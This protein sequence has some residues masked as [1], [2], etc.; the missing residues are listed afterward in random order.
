[1]IGKHQAIYCAW[2]ASK[3]PDSSSL[4]QPIYSHCWISRP[5]L[6]TYL[7]I[8]VA[9]KRDEITLNVLDSLRNTPYSVSELE[10]LSGGTA[11]FIYLAELQKP[12]EDG[13]KEVIVKHSEDFIANHPSFKL[14]QDRSRIEVECLKALSQLSAEDKAES[15]DFN[16]HVRTPKV[17]HFDGTDHT[18]VQEYLPDSR[19]LKTYALETLPAHTPETLKPQCCQ[20]GRGLGKWLRNLH[21]WSATQPHLRQVVASNKEM[22]DLKHMI[23]FAWLLDRVDQYPNVLGD[24]KDVFVE[25][26]AMAR[27]ELKDESQL[28]VLHGDFWPGNILLPDLPIEKGKDVPMFVVDWELA[29]LGVPSLDVGQMMANL[30]Q[31][32][33]YKNITAALWMIQGF[34]EGYGRT[35]EEFAFRTAIQTGVHLVAFGNQVSGW[36]TPEQIEKSIGIGKDIIVHAWRKDKAWFEG[37]ELACLFGQAPGP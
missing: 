29:S 37:G 4:I 23:N 18:Q 17:Y 11:N 7:R 12:L 20:L 36:G 14:T 1:M 13:T 35:D 6:P 15:G 34:V 26:K 2:T 16:Y 24:A 22:Q 31:V 9:T 3:L 5:K 28:Q 21:G 27:A 25:V 10:P 32:K 19:D 30:Y 8:M 33:L